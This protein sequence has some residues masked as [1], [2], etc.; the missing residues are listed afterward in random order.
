MLRRLEKAEVI[1][2]NC[3]IPEHCS[4]T[5]VI[6]T[7]LVKDFM[8]KVLLATTDAVDASALLRCAYSL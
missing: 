2:S 3:D 4:L 1:H 5:E 7:N 6:R 8:S